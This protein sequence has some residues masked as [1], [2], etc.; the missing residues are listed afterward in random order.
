MI[1]TG[2]YQPLYAPWAGPEFQAQYEPIRPFTCVSADRCYVIDRLL[3]HVLLVTGEI[4]ECGVWKGG[5]AKLISN[6]LKATYNSQ[7]LRLF[8]TF[9]GM[10]ETGEKDNFHK[11]GDF[12]DTSL[13]AVQALVGDAQYH[14]GRIPETFAEVPSATWISFAHIDVDI[15]QSVTDCLSFIWPRLYR[16]GAIVIDDYGFDTCVGARRATDEFFDKTIAYPIC[17]PTGQAIVYK[18]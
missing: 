4:W 18:I 16:G 11:G 5:T 7:T 9:A 3:R 14:A 10:P 12:A 6:V 2:P 8:D 15:Y 1:L 13:E 17:L